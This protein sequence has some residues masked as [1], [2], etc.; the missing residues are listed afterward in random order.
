MAVISNQMLDE[1]MEANSCTAPSMI[2]NTYAPANNRVQQELN[3][4]RMT[5]HKR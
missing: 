1:L 3:R 4:K 5:L 2:Q